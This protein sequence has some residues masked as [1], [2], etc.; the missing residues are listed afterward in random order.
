MN[1]GKSYDAIVIGSG[2]TGGFAA[3][4]L[5]ERGLETLVLEAG[6]RLP[7]ADFHR[8]GAGLASI[9]SWPRIKAGLTG[10]PRQARSTFFAP[11]KRFLFVNDFKNP[12]TCSPETFY[13]WL[14][15]RNVG[16]RFLAWGRCAPRMSDYDF[17]S[18]SRSGVGEDWPIGYDDLA[19][20]YERVE[21]FL[22]IIGT[23]DGIANLPD[24][25]YKA[26]AGL[27]K[28]ER[29]FKQTVESTW[30]NRK[31]VPWRY[32]DEAATPVD[33]ETGTRTTAPLAAAK[34]TTRLTLRP[35][36][37]VERINVDPGTGRAAGVTFIDAETCQRHEVSGNV[38]VLCASTIESIRLLLNSGSTRHPNGLGNSSGLLG[39]YFMDQCLSVCFGSVPGSHGYELVDGTSPANNHGGVYIPRFT[40]LDGITHPDFFHGFN[41]QGIIG[42][43]PVPDSHPSVFGLTAHGEMPAYRHN[44][45]TLNR[46]KKDSWGVPAAHISLKLTDN[47]RH[48][49]RAEL[50]ALKEMVLANGYHID[51]AMNLLGID[52]TENFLPRSNWVERL[53]FRAAYR[54]SVA[55]GAAI[56][57]CGGARMGSDPAQSVI[58]GCNQSWDV[59]NLFVTDSSCFV[60]SGTC[61]P[62]LTT[63][64]LTTRACEYIAREY[65]GSPNLYQAA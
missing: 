3:K 6:P 13:L 64:A 62:T 54:K 56:H 17:K 63:M 57:E 43:P 52:S 51:F 55:I 7:E 25:K 19:P 59:P 48:L 41:I 36:S 26:T 29:A 45:V 14:R 60:S 46:R 33:A 47:E 5:T 38:V 32:V 16:G 20:Y 23:A 44:T 10:Q 50:A 15:G 24:G 9:G 30:P 28:L 39:R 49:M 22:G 40:N 53:T 35:N 21:E 4:E 61:G 65:Q 1:K 34:A 12:Y 8:K 2:A 42:R 31:V 58:N 11:E 27:S 37:I 18:A